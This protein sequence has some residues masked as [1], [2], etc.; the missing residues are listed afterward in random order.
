MA[1]QFISQQRYG[2]YT[3]CTSRAGRPVDELSYQPMC[4]LTFASCVLCYIVAD[5]V[6]AGLCP[7][8]VHRRLGA[9]NVLLKTATLDGVVAKVA[10]FGPMKDD[11]ERANAKV[12]NTTRRQRCVTL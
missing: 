2:S 8:I 7:Q 9:R 4:D 12:S 6:T 11:V 10:G 5:S 1:V 3:P